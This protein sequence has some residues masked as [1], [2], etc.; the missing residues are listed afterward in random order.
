MAKE[1]VFIAVF[2]KHS[3]RKNERGITTNEW[4]VTETVEFV[5]QLRNKHTS[6]ASVIGDYL[7]RKMIS[8]SRFGFTEY[9]NFENYVR[10]KY[11]KQMQEL[12][13][14]YGPMRVPKE[15]VD[16]IVS[17]QFGNLRPKTVFDV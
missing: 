7:G 10:K 9:E 6:M 12:D 16:E 8:G 2:H 1:K 5:N 14:S 13:E 4:E 3:L 15:V 17:D 11:P